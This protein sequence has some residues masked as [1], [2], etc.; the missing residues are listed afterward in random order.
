MTCL[1]IVGGKKHSEEV[2]QHSINEVFPVERS[3]HSFLPRTLTMPRMRCGISTSS[4]AE[5]HKSGKQTQ[6]ASL[7]T[8]KGNYTY[9]HNMLGSKR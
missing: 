3:A 7:I 8:S 9:Q 4:R 2:C 1:I 5:E 6:P